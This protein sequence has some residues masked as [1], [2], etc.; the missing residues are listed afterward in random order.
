MEVPTKWPRKLNSRKEKLKTLGTRIYSSRTNSGR[1]ELNHLDEIRIRFIICLSFIK[2][3][4]WQAM[5]FSYYL[6]FLKRIE[7]WHSATFRKVFN[8][9]PLGFG[10]NEWINMITNEKESWMSHRKNSKW[11]MK[12]YE[13]P[14]R[15]RRTNKLEKI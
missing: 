4:W 3:N 7:K 10:K 9:P 6:F 8:E 15:I 14:G 13:S 5:D 11:L 2:L 12:E 1:K